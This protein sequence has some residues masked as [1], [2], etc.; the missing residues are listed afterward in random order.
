MSLGEAVTFDFADSNPKVLVAIRAGGLAAESLIYNEPFENLMSNPAVRRAVKGD[1]DNA[2]QDLENA[3]LLFPSSSDEEFVWLFRM[4]FDDAVCML[5]GSQ[6]KLL[7]IANY[8]LA[9]QNRDIAMAELVD[10]CDL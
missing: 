8:C 4:G 5:R 7:R 2:R 10:K 6:D 1:T 3:R 9:N